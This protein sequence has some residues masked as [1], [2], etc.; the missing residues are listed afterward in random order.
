[1]IIDWYVIALFFTLKHF[2][3]TVRHPYRSSWDAKL[4]S[5]INHA[6]QLRAKKNETS[7]KRQTHPKRKISPMPTTLRRRDAAQCSIR[8]KNASF[9]YIYKLI[10]FWANILLKKWKYNSQFNNK[11]G[12]KYR[13]SLNSAG[14]NSEVSL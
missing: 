11:C 8:C 14:S 7:H 2:K 3:S 1:M 9:L 13:G 6:C 12:Y 10:V 5:N 4:T